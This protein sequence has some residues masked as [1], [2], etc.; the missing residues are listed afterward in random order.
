MKTRTVGHDKPPVAKTAK[1]IK[2][3][4]INNKI[5]IN[6]KIVNMK[7]YTTPILTTTIMNIFISLTLT[8]IILSFMMICK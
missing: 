6:Y 1:T 7:T 8:L 5:E 3:V 4:N 2:T